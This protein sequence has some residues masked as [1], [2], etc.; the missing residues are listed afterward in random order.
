MAGLLLASGLLL[1]AAQSGMTF[2]HDD[3][4][5][6]L[7]RRDFGADALLNPFNEHIVIA[8]VAIY[9]ASIAL[10]GIDSALPVQ[11][12]SDLLV[13]T[14]GALLFIYARSRV[15]DWLAVIA[16]AL[17]LFFGSAW[18]D[19]LWPIN[20]ALSGGCAAGLGALLALD[21]NDRA[22][23]IAAA[24]LLA[25]S[26]LFSEVGVAF[27]VGALASVVLADRPWRQRLFIPAV[28]LALYA[29][30]W[31]GWG[32]DADS[33]FSLDNVLDSPAYVFDAVSQALAAL[34]GLGRPFSGDASELVGI[35]IG[36]VLLVVAAALAV[37]RLRGKPVPS[38][39][40][41]AL[42]AGLAFWLS[43]AFTENE[44]RPPTSARILLPSAIFILL[45]AVEVLRGIRPS[46]SATVVVAGV[47]ALAVASNLQALRDGA[48]VFETTSETVRADLAAVERIQ[49]ANPDYILSGFPWLLP[50]P[51]SDYLEAVEETDSS[52]AYSDSELLE[53]PT[54][55][56]AHADAVISAA[57]GLVLQPGTSVPSESDS[58]CRRMATSPDGQTGV[59]FGPGRV[60]MADLGGVTKR[61]LLAR[62][63]TDAYSVDLGDL[64]AG[65]AATLEVPA[66][67]SEQPWLL[68]LK[69]EG[70]VIV[71]V[72]P[73]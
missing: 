46:P 71:C 36:R 23:D 42:A 3:W 51:A 15:G 39:V 63:S 69:G 10:F 45:I 35:G 64:P 43:A 67:R 72:R 1:L 31:A 8:L 47:A 62:Y 12:V 28:P 25:V 60:I 29:L 20:L 27:S 9:D 44:L 26:V 37:L 32:H 65:G 48:E 18:L 34:V 41:V 73:G 30:W 40:W 22:G 50:V 16:A 13:L 57:L 56:R 11:I 70:P 4:G 52:T 49:D 21:R 2:I 61:V 59:E 19:L 54:P 68:G 14:C 53:A 55:A 66:D 6:L 33:S 58:G 24:V 38:G 5:Y 17:I 7:Y